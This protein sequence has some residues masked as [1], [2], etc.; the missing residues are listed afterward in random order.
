MN[1]QPIIR[2]AE[3]NDY[4]AVMAI[5]RESYRVHSDALP[6]DYDLPHPE[7][8]FKRGTFLN[9]LE[10]DEEKIYV[11]TIGGTIVGMIN[12]LIESVDATKYHKEYKRVSVE[13]ICVTAAYQRQGIGRML[14][15][16]AEKWAAE[17]EIRD[18][19]VIVY[20]FNKA[21]IS[22]YD[23]IGYESYSIRMRK[24]INR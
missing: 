20:S 9:I 5:Y 17:K 24:L 8:P 14:M 1:D 18:I 10:D 12:F 6:E 16:E 13:E 3:E 19:T 15:A 22:L 4:E 7:Y 2:L 11:A 23:S 21:A